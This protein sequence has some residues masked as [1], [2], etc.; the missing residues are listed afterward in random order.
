MTELGQLEGRT[1]KWQLAYF[2]PKVVYF[3]QIF[4]DIDFKFVLLV[5]YIKIDKQIIL[6]VIRTQNDYLSLKKPHKWSYLNS[7]FSKVSVRRNSKFCNFGC[8]SYFS[9]IPFVAVRG[10]NS[11][12]KN[13]AGF[14]I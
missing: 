8:N 12:N 2:G 5:T 4:Q 1:L 14:L 10:P 13:V 11:S 7:D 6:G 9:I 3:G